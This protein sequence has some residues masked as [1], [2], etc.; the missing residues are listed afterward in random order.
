MSLRIAHEFQK[1]N[2]FISQAKDKPKY[3]ANQKERNDRKQPNYTDL[4]TDPELPGQTRKFAVKPG[5]NR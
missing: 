2:L 5:Q 4:P 1:I 3:T